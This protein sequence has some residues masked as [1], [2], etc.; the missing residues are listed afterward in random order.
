[1]PS[2]DT[3]HEILLNKLCT[4]LSRKELRDLVDVRE[5]LRQ[6]GDLGRALGEAPRKDGGFSPLMLAWILRGA[7][8]QEMAPVGGLSSA[9]QVELEQF[10]DDLVARLTQMARPEPG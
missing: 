9:E 8:I 7:S 4:L 6:G 3:S 2:S 1:M 10:R 5:L